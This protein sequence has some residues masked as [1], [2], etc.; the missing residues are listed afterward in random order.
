MSDVSV[1]LNWNGEMRFTGV[2]AAGHETLIDGNKRAAASPVEVLLEALGACTG[3]DVV[4]ILEKMRTQAERVEIALDGNRQQTEPRYYTDVRLRFDVWGDGINP[5]KLARAIS[6][7]LEKYCSVYHS[8]RPDLKT[9][10]EFR[11]HAT[12]AEAAGE[13]HIVESNN[14]SNITS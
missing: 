12:G 14:Q 3:I 7:S 10:A 11:I 2:N 13:Y 9:V 8:L 6:L 4:L 1:K 5:D